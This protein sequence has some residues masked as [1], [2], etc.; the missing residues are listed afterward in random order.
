MPRKK[1]KMPA[2][3]L[4][5]GELGLKCN[6]EAFGET[7]EDVLKKI[8]KHLHTDHAIHEYDKWID[9]CRTRV[10]DTHRGTHK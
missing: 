10:R 8:E 3:V 4:R 2:K 9:A 7:E 6:F 5:C 1:E